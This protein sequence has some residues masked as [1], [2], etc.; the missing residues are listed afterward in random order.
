MR[1]SDAPSAHPHNGHDDRWCKR[2]KKRPSSPLARDLKVTR[3]TTPDGLACVITGELLMVSGSVGIDT[4]RFHP[5]SV[6][7]DTCSG[8][9]L[10]AC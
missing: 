5:H 3:H 8:C 6:A 2:R 9:N 1:P 10:I 4:A 7:V